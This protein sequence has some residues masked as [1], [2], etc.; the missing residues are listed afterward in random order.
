[1]ALVLVICMFLLPFVSVNGQEGAYTKCSSYRTLKQGCPGGW[2]A[3]DTDCY[4]FIQQPLM[5]LAKAQA[6]CQNSGGVLLR[7]D[8]LQQHY[9]I[10]D[11]LNRIST[12]TSLQ[13]FT[14]GMLDPAN[15]PE[16]VWQSAPTN[17]Q[18]VAPD[19]YGLWITPPPTARD[20]PNFNQNSPS[21]LVY[22][23]NNVRWGWDL[24]KAT[25]TLGYIC[26]APK[27]QAEY[28]KTLTRTIDYGQTDMNNIMFGPCFLIQPEDQWFITYTITSQFFDQQDQKSSVRFECLA[29]GNPNPMYRWYRTGF[30]NSSSTTL[31]RTLIDPKTMMDGRYA[32][33]GG[34]LSIMNPEKSKDSFK[35]QC[36]AYNSFG[37]VLTQTASI[38]FA[39]IDEY[40]KQSRSPIVVE[41]YTS[42]TLSCDPPNPT[43]ASLILHYS[44]L[45]KNWLTN[46]LEPVRSEFRP[47]L[48]VSLANGLLGFSEV[49]EQDKGD[50]VCMVSIV[51]PTENNRKQ[52]IKSP[53]IPLVVIQSN[54]P[55][56][57]LRIQDFFPAVWPKEPIRGKPARVECF[58]SGDLRRGPL[59][60]TWSREDGKPIDKSLIKDSG[61]V[62]EF[63]AV[64]ISDQGFY[65]CNVRDANGVKAKAEKTNLSIKDRPYFL[66]SM[67]D[68]VVDI[69][70]TAVLSCLASG[71]PA[72]THTWY[73][74][75]KTVMSLLLD[76]T[77]SSARYN[78]TEGTSSEATLMIATATLEDSGMFSCIA[79]NGH[80]STAS[81]GELKILQLAPNFQKFPL[82][83]SEAMVGGTTVLSC[84]PEAAPAPEGGT[85]WYKDNA[86]LSVQPTTIDSLTGKTVC[87]GT[88]CRLPSG[89]LFI[90]TI[91]MGSSGFYECR[92]TNKFGTAS[93]T[94]LLTI[95]EELKAVLQ[96]S[97][98]I[99]EKG[100]STWIPC[101]AKVQSHLDVNYA[102][103]YQGLEIGF[104]R[105]DLDARR[106]ELS[107]FF[108][109][110]D[111]YFGSMQITNIQYDNEG[112]YQ[113]RI[114]TA[115]QTLTNEGTILLNGPPG[116]FPNKYKA[117]SG[118]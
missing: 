34:Q 65:I 13:W 4:Y 30:S 84:Q 77:L 76:G 6:E 108:R 19:L 20:K 117:E 89:N 98:R 17:L 24:A 60:Y 1:M 68:A 25:D 61:R 99:V 95:V 79:E 80:G 63:Q 83:P 48:F 113:C 82:F 11:E 35:F 46:E 28:L 29:V 39:S 101:R 109:P 116:K 59:V 104:D 26:Q 71:I 90:S 12:N 75:S 57:N 78:L 40:E 69:G 58:A 44:F 45:M 102:W 64:K 96:P 3:S 43:G 87:Q 51:T 54:S 42:T 33:V 112:V 70:S 49:T 36:E 50:Y 88:Y 114:E 31:Q 97:N 27:D 38:K 41:A 18:N 115:L 22:A 7:I 23:F 85:L 73:K 107:K 81:S 2:I 9:F 91:S 15:F 72:P 47:G 37:S 62:I 103:Y 92:A 5:T 10:A 16:F 94:G 66:R 86:A 56:K 105:L 53:D 100:T 118:R 21:R 106:Y 8:N 93:S 74:G 67:M 111:R 110:F 55:Q 14:S 52:S 32:I